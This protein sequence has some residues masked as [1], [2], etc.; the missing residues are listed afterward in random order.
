MIICATYN[1]KGGVGKTAAA[2]NLAHLASIHGYR[3]LVW[4]L[5][6]QGAASFYLRG[7]PLAELDLEDLLDRK[8]GIMGAIRATDYPRLDLL[9][10]TLAYRNLD[11]A[12]SEFKSPTKRLGKLLAPLAD[13][14]DLA[15]LDCAPNLSVASENVFTLA[16]WLL[17]PIIPTPLSIR[18]Y[19][20]LQAFWSADAVISAKFLPFFS[21]VD[22]RRQLQCELVTTFAQNH[23][24]VLRSFIPY[25]SQVERMGEQR[26]PVQT[27]APASPGARAFVALWQALC[28]RIAIAPGAE[29]G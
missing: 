4:D 27:F 10:S 11:V 17:I 14:Y 29:N 26:A 20:Q 24:E 1:I 7:E 16:D 2:V 23:P 6:P 12:L 3:T 21:M 19:E 28:A 22:R 5:D 13:R 9:P 15:F 8:R 18:A 25:A